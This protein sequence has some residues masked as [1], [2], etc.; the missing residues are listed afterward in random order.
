[1]TSKFVIK[2]KTYLV[3]MNELQIDTFASL[4]EPGKNQGSF[5]QIGYDL[6]Q[7]GKLDQA[8]SYTLVEEGKIF[9]FEDAAELE[10]LIK[11]QLNIIEKQIICME[12][13]NQIISS[14]GLKIIDLP[15][16]MN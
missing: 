2:G 1:M 8:L 9:N 14:Y 4:I 12:A 11:N 10:T 15:F 6:V 3:Q 16:E 7:S 13:F 5:T